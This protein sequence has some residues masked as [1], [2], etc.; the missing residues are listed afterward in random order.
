MRKPRKTR[1]PHK[2]PGTPETNCQALVW[3]EETQC[4]GCQKE[5][6]KSAEAYAVIG[7]RRVIKVMERALCFIF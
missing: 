7:S 3:T 1:E 5:E 2:C 6:A 4:E